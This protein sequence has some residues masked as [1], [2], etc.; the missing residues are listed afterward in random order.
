MRRAKSFRIGVHHANGVVWGLVYRT[1]LI[2]IILARLFASQSCNLSWRCFRHTS[3]PQL[4]HVYAFTALSFSPHPLAG[5]RRALRAS[6]CLEGSHDPPEA[7]RSYVTWTDS[8]GTCL[9][10]PPHSGH[11]TH[12][13]SCGSREGREEESE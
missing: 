13:V 1:H 11:T 9:T 10:P 4:L 8:P 2:I 3:E 7:W 5:H 6:G 12:V